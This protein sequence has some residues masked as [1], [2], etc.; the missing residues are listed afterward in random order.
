MPRGHQSKLRTR[1]KRRQAQGDTRSVQG[2]QASTTEEEGST[3]SSSPRFGWPSQSSH[4]A[5]TTQGS[6]R[7]PSTSTGAIAAS[8]RR[9]PSGAEGQDEGGPSSSSARARSERSQ[10]VRLTSRV[11]M[12]SQFLMYKYEMQRQITKREMLKFINKRYK[13]HFPEIL[14]RTSE[15]LELVFGLDVKKVDSKGRSYTIVSKLEIAEEENL[16]GGREFPKT[17]LLMP[18]LATISMK[19]NRVTEEEMWEFLNVFGMY[20]GKVHYIFGEPRALITG[21]LQA[22]YLEYR[23]VF[24]SNPPRYEFLWGPRAQAEASK[25]ILLEFSSKLNDT[26]SGDFQGLYE[27]TLGGEEE[28][29]AGREWA[30]AGLHARACSSERESAAGPPIR[31]EV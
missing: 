27:E 17:G 30:R 9:A 5:R 28:R 23:Q 3:S 7:A 12:L 26:C 13:E 14:R 6:Q 4:A 2:A 8:G 20:D 1:G 10:R 16:S 11:I 24:N 22:K 29:G 18:L 21:L 15:Y 19:G 31:G 25:K